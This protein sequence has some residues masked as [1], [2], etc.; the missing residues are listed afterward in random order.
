MESSVNN[1]LQNFETHMDRMERERQQQEHELQLAK[2]KTRLAKVEARA[3]TKE[4]ATIW[5]SIIAGVGILLVIIWAI[6]TGV[7]GP[8]ADQQME[9]ESRTE[10]ISNGGTFIPNVGNGTKGS[11]ICILPGSIK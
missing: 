5:L 3:D 11:D 9:R 4:Q 10:C 6:Y 2:E 8:S 7:A 1:E